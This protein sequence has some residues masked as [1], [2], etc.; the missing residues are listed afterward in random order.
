MKALY[1]I[2]MSLLVG[3]WSVISPYAL[4]FTANV[5]AYWNSLSVGALLILLS[6]VGIYVE[7]EDLNAERFHHSSK[8]KTA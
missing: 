2:T 4:N 1:W 6:L 5:E 7:W 3:V 8:T